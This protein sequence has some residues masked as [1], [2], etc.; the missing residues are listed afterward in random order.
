MKI[1]MIL[2]AAGSASRFGES[3]LE[4]LIGKRSII[5][6]ILSSIPKESYAK[7]AIV[8]ATQNILDTAKRYGISGAIND[9]PELGIARS[10]K[11][12]T[13]LMEGMDAYMYCVSD[14]PLL[15]KSTIENMINAYGRNTIL[16]LSCDGKRGN[17]V[18][19]PSFLHDELISLKIDESGQ[20]VINAHLDILKLYDIADS[21]QLM[22]IDT[23]EDLD[24]IIKIIDKKH[25]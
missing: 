17:P 10:I 14:Q 5:K 1:G 3:K 18:I 24:D 7:I 25:S 23:K 21:I 15:A 16:A 2:L 20:K 12:G 8:A 22:D 9:K 19:F 11:I 6:Y 4:T 13:E